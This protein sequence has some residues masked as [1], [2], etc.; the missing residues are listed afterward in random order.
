MANLSKDIQCVSFDTRPP[1]LDKTD[2]ASWQQHIRLYYQGKEN[3]ATNILLQ[4]LPKDIYT[5]INHYTD[6]KD[7]WDNV[8]MLLEGSNLTKEDQESQLYDDF[9]QFRQHKGETI[10]YYYVR[11]TKLIND[12][13]NIKMAMSKLQLNSKF[14]NN[15]LPE[16]GRFVTAVKLN[17]GLRDFN[18]DQLYAYLKQHETHT[19]ENKMMLDR[20]SLHTVDPLALMSN[21]SYQQHY[22]QS[23]LTPPSTYVSPHLA[24]NTHR[25]G[26]NPRGG[27]AI[28]YGGVQNRVGNANPGQARQDLTLN[29]DNVFQDDDCDAFNSDVDEAPTTQTVFMA[30]LSSADPVTDEARPSYDS[31][32]LSE[33]QDHDHYWD[34]VC[35]HHEEHAM[36]DNVQLNHVVDSHADYTSDSNMIPYDQYVKD[37]AVPVVYIVEKSLTAKLATYMEQVELY[38]RRAKFE[39]T[40][41]EQKINK[42]LRL[43]ISDRNFKEETLKKELQSIKLQLASTTN[44]N[45]LMVEEVTSMRKDFKQKEN[46]YLEDFLDMKSLKEKVEDRL[47][48]QDQSLQTVHMLYR[49]KPYYNELNKVAIGYKNP[50]CL[51]R[52]KEQNT[53]S[54]P[55]KALTVY[56]PNTPATLVP[57]VLP[58]K[59]QVKIHIF[60]LI[61]LFL[62]FDKTCKKRIT[63]T[64][65]TEGKGVLNKPRHVISRRKHDEIK[66]K[67]L[68][69]AND[70]LIA[71][72]LSKEVFSV[73]TNS[74]LNV[75]RFTEMHVANNIVEARCLELEAELFNL[76]H[77][78]HND[79]HDELVNRFSNL[80]KTNILVPPS[81]RVN[82]C[83]NASGSKPRSNTKKN[84]ISPAKGVNKLQVEEQSRTNKS[85]L[86]TLNRVDSSSRPKRTVINSNSDYVCQAC[87]KYLISANHDMCVVDYLQSV[88]APPLFVIIVMLC[89]K[90]SKFGKLGKLDK[91]HSCYVQD[92]D[93]V[94]LIKGS[95]GS[96]LY[97]I[98]VKDIMKSSPICLLSKASKNK[99]WLWHRRLN[100][101]NFGTINDLARKDLVRGLPRLKFEKDHFCFVCQLGKSKKHTHKSKT[102]NTN[103][104]VLNTLQMDLC[105]PMRVQIINGKKYILVIVDDYS[106][107]IWVKI[108]RSKYETPE[109]VPR[110]P[111]QN[112]VVERQN[113]TL[114]EAARTMLIFSKA[115][116]VFSALYYP[117]NDNE[118]LGKLQPTADIG[119]FIGY[120]PSRKVQAPV[121]SAGIPSSTTIDQDAHSLSISP[122]SLALQSYSLHQGITAESTFIEDNPV[123]PVDNNPF[124]NV[125]ATEP[126]SDASS[127]GD[128]SSTK[129]T[130]VSRTLHHLIEPK[131]FKSAI[132]KDCWFQAMQDEIHEF[133]RLQVWE[134]VPQPD[135][136]MIITLKWIYK[137]KLDEYGDVLKNKARLVAKGYRQEEGIN[138][139]E[140]F[141]PVARIEAIRILIANATSKNMTI[142]QMDVKKAFLN[143]E[144]KEEVYVSQPEGF[145]DPDHPT[146][147][148]RLK[149]ALYGLKQAPRAWS[150]H[151]DIRHHFIREQVEKGVVELYFVTT[152]NQLTDIFTKALPRE[153]FEF[154]LPRLDTMADVN[155]NAPTDQAPTMAPPTR[156]DDQIPPHIRW[157]TIGKNEQ[158]FDLTKD[159]LRDA[160]QITP[161][162][163]N[164]A[165]SSPPLSDALINFVNE[166]G[167][168][169]LIRNLSN[170]ITNDMFQPSRALTTFI[171]LCLMGKTSGFERPRAPRKHKFHPRLDFPLYLPNEEPVL[172]YFKFSAMR[173]K[174]EVFRMP[175][176]GNL[177]TADIQGESYYQEYLEK[178]AKHQRYL[179]DETGSDPNFLVPKLTKTAKKSKQTVPKADPRSPVLK[180]AS[181]QQPEPKPAPAKTQ[182]KKHESVAEGIREKELSV[183]DEGADVQRALEEILKSIYDVPWGPLPPVVI[184]EPESGK[185]QPLLEVQGKGKEKVIEEQVARDLLT[186][187]TPK[188]KSP[189]DQYIF[190]RR[191]S[192]PTGFYGHDKSLSL[193]AK[194]GLMD[195]KAGPN[196]DKQAEGHAGPNPGD[197]EASQPPPS[198]VVHAGSDLE[199]MDLDVADVST[200]PHPE[201]MDEGFT[202]MA[203]LK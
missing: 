149:K 164:K 35:A 31:D 182:G 58:T 51:T 65:L 25:Q 157:V 7:I 11:F 76:L 64:G 43:V 29:V 173:T 60:T 120:A 160:L 127:S 49:P 97:T 141:V 55:I 129:S 107:F 165:F 84:M 20:F 53:V 158:W 73:A 163:N 148:Y 151:I 169:K 16:W 187:Q 128:V 18:Y 122:S 125:F 19:N 62:E 98:S 54:R 33:V 46:K 24:D 2:F 57:R 198:P 193:Y 143:G 150:K 80:E 139:E 109:K 178:V 42:Q 123:A 153:R 170:V 177:I 52:T 203:Y 179:A 108:L 5:L 99:S 154:L 68:L 41:R 94:E 48:K 63:P 167:Y 114:V 113:R 118:D 180:P 9:E 201:K 110:T 176:P 194:L 106:R 50:L 89:T 166:L 66:R 59:S 132:T 14:V 190:Q 67:N 121:N 172:G 95:R 38:E 34:A 104:E 6:A 56:P 192:A 196:P 101:L 134:L 147:V 199:H 124:I 61:Q 28:G 162:N 92:T 195:S 69:I 78:N 168:L 12:M 83:K 3:E 197:A 17:R 130:Y 183:D 21:V 185:Y 188:K 156:T 44:H 13:R 32:I 1:M 142:Y 86:R 140:S 189:T 102:E 126:N 4:G 105:G 23:S 77:K 144:L 81:T 91:K 8:K 40:K 135:Y 145:V 15:M 75:A 93:G 79:N 10:H 117:T 131:N 112:G 26:T 137:V 159:T 100:H 161:V 22:S 111:Q 85:H 133:D 136:V 70:N 96:N 186:L 74:E 174:R 90:L 82:R 103:L 115:P 184:K 116:I 36:H 27:G 191:T 181:S 72:C 171:N 202:A 152:D 39:L 45:K 200:Q 175:I 138:F 71:D 146:H 88:V 47:F 119:I 37:N 155:I 87:N 30:N